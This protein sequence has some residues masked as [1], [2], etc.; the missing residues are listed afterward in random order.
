MP[1]PPVVFRALSKNLP[2]KLGTNHKIFGKS[3]CS[4]KKTCFLTASWWGALFNFFPPVTKGRKYCGE[5]SR[6]KNQRANG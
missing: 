2:E 4:N 5:H 1:A 3:V 6:R